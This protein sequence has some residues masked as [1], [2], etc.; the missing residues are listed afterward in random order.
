MKQANIKDLG[1]T[2]WQSRVPPALNQENTYVSTLAGQSVLQFSMML[3]TESRSTC[4]QTCPKAK[5]LNQ[6]YQK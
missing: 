6:S 5:N 4:K 1:G 3:V 2:K